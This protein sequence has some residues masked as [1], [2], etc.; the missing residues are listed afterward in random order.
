VAILR[1]NRD[2]GDVFRAK[3]KLTVIRFTRV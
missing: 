2:S 1:F 3:V